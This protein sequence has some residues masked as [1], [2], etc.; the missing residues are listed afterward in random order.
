MGSKPAAAASSLG[1]GVVWCVVCAINQDQLKRV[2]TIELS[3]YQK[4]FHGN[5]SR[6]I[7]F[8]K[9]KTFPIH[10]DWNFG[11]VPWLVKTESGIIVSLLRF[12]SFLQPFF[13]QM[14]CRYSRFFIGQLVSRCTWPNM[15]ISRFQIFHLS[16]QMPICVFLDHKICSTHDISV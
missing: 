5:R 10:H 3:A 6:I 14:H 11:V 4:A 8:K 1:G 15:Q 13:A 9:L 12:N 2:Q 16:A 7:L